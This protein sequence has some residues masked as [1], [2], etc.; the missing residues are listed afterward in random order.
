LSTGSRVQRLLSP[1][2][3][4]VAFERPTADV[5]YLNGLS[6]LPDHRSKGGGARLVHYT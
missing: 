6:V 1:S 5:A 4:S 2:V 3:S